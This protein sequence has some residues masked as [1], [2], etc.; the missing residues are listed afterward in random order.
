MKSNI[1]TFVLLTIIAFSLLNPSYGV[2]GAGAQKTDSSVIPARTLNN[3]ATGTV[4]YG[5]VVVGKYQQ[6][7]DIQG[8]VVIDGPQLVLELNGINISADASL[9]KIADKTWTYNYL[10][11][12]DG[13]VGDI[14]L[15]IHPYTV[16][17]NGKTAGNVHT[18]SS[19]AVQVIHVPYV[20][21][22]SVKDLTWDAYDPTN[23]VINYSYTLTKIWDDGTE[24]DSTDRITG[25]V[26]GSETAL[27]YGS[28]VTHNGGIPSLT[29]TITPPVYYRSFQLLS[30][31]NDYIWTYDPEINAFSVAFE[32]TKLYSDNSTSVQT[33]V[34]DG[35]VP[36]SQNTVV[37]LI[38]GQE[39]TFEF[40]APMAPVDKQKEETATVTNV[41]VVVIGVERIANNATQNNVK[42][43]YSLVVTLSNGITFDSD[44]FTVTVPLNDGNSTG[45]KEVSKTL[46]FNG[47]DYPVTFTV[48][49]IL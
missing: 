34:I 27:L 24:V 10:Y 12:F 31:P 17:I 39:Q 14:P 38:E 42:A 22:F 33:I 6:S 26:E 30:E 46:S 20:Q 37:A 49:V 4:T 47:I 43:T 18:D 13:Q 2:Y 36:N 21:A 15:N 44:D 25:L 32:I 5:D 41:Q 8:I 19:A 1:K 48:D 16:F 9:K 45:S 40:Y 35:L 29:A 28:D 23:N 3:F 7:V 11:R